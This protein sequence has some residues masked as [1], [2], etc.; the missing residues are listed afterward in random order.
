MDSYECACPSG[1]TGVNCEM[2]RCTSVKC[3]NLVYRFF[4]LPLKGLCLCIASI[5]SNSFMCNALESSHTPSIFVF[6]WFIPSSLILVFLCTPTSF[7]YC[8][9]CSTERSTKKHNDEIPL[10]CNPKC[11]LCLNYYPD[12]NECADMGCGDRKICINFPGTSFC[13]CRPGFF[14]KENSCDRGTD[15]LNY[16]SQSCSCMF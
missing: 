5:Y 7:F 3:A 11:D 13:N 9:W 15:S 4:T 2:G 12:I 6:F 16:A 14:D 10:C 1:Y 8:D